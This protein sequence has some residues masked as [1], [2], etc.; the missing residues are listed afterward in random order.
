LLRKLALALLKQHPLK[1]SV[2]RK[3]KRVVGSPFF[4]PLEMRVP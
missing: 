1:D 4:G 3:R 2:A